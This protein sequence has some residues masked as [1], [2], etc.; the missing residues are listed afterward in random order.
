MTYSDA[1]SPGMAQ[2]Y[3]M[4]FF[5]LRNKGWGDEPATLADVAERSQ[6]SARNF[7]RVMKGEIADPPGGVIRRIRNGYLQY[8]AELVARLQHE[9]EIEKKVHGDAAFEDLGDEVAALVA[10]VEA[11]KARAI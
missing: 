4:K 5:Q 6:M 11:A 10:K 1:L 9:I 2:K 3:A 7:K 8:C